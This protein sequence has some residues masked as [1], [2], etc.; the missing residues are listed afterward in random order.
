MRK[1][2]ESSEAMSNEKNM[3]LNGL[4]ILITKA[5]QSRSTCLFAAWSRLVF[6]TAKKWNVVFWALRLID[7]NM[8]SP[9]LIE[10]VQDVHVQPLPGKY[11]RYDWSTIFQILPFGGAII[12]IG[13]TRNPNPC[14]GY[15]TLS[16]YFPHQYYPSWM[17]NFSVHKSF[18]ELW[19][20]LL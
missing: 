11:E 17:L 14:V 1:N 6:A 12:R 9:G 15:V 18:L 5:I 10:H 8:L 4:D 7:L 19:W 13:D 2:L 3:G 20:L 16:I